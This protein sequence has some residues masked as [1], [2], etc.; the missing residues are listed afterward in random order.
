MG[1]CFSTT[2]LAA[3]WVAFW[4][5]VA[6]LGVVLLWG[7]VGRLVYK[8]VLSSNWIILNLD[9]TMER[10]WMRFYNRE[11]ELEVLEKAYSRPGADLVV[12]SGRRRI[13][14]SRLIDEFAKDK[15]TIT[16]LI[17]PKEERQV[18]KDLEEE[19]RVKTGYSPPFRFLKDALE[20]LFEQNIDLVCLD[21]FPNLLVVNQAIPYELQRLWDKHKDSKNLMFIVSGSYAGMMNRLFAAKK[22]PLFNRA[23]NTINVPQLSFSTAVEVLTDFGVISASEQASFYCVF[24]GVPF[25]YV[26]LEKLEDRSFV[27]AVHSLFFD[28][29]AQLKEEGENVLRQEF[30]NAYAKY[31]AILEAISAGYVSMNE[32]SQKVGVRSTTLTKYMKALQHDFKIVERIVP[33]GENPARSKKGLYFIRDNTLAFWFSAVYGKPSAPSKDEYSS[34]IG[35]RFEILCR[36]FLGAYLTGKGEKVLGTGKWWGPVK[37]E[38]KFEPREIDVVLE[39]DKAMYFGE[40]KWTEQKMGERELNW[41][42][43]SAHAVAGKKK[44]A[45][46]FVLFSKK[47]FD[48][49]ENEE[50]LLFDA[51]RLVQDS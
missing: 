32:I 51:K 20:Y 15:K 45:V 25:Y 23:T 47:G 31:Y 43:E 11:K 26:L 14:K 44:K 3:F 34:F 29:G 24:G 35:R 41:L 46:R 48:I 9:N 7:S 33:F 1:G 36:E 40:C 42:K 2:S 6:F 16:V 17:V 28:V 4:V 49:S 21:E 22:A 12:V 13:G 19:I 39:T 38:G 10:G 27:N 18:A 8:V 37:V 5:W 50:V 30:G